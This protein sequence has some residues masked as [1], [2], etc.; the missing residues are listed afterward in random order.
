MI[1]GVSSVLQLPVAFNV[2]TLEEI[3]FPLKLMSRI[4]WLFSQ[5][6][7]RTWNGC[8]WTSL[9]IK[10]LAEESINNLEIIVNYTFIFQVVDTVVF[11][12]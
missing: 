11:T 1:D 5:V 10:P 4:L 7:S 2:I 12:V 6:M 8:V 3:F 9:K